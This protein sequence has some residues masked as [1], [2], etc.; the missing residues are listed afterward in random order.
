MMMTGI[1]YYHYIRLTIVIATLAASQFSWSAYN[2]DS[3]DFNPTQSQVKHSLV[4]W[5]S[6]EDGNPTDIDHIVSL[7]DAHISGGS[8]WSSEEK[9]TF[10]NDPYNQ[11]ASNPYVNRVIKNKHTPL[12]FITRMLTSNYGFASSKCLRYL[13]RYVGVKAKYGLKLNLTEIESASHL[14]MTL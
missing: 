10:S 2:R 8:A 9:R 11:V 1:N 3:W 14:C 12:K 13:D 4:G 7:N 5:Y 6:G